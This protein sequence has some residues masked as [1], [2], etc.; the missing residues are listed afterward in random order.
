MNTLPIT[1]ATFLAAFSCSGANQT[2]APTSKSAEPTNGPSESTESLPL[3]CGDAAGCL[4][5]AAELDASDPELATHA[6][7][8]ACSAGAVEGCEQAGLRWAKAV[9]TTPSED[10]DQKVLDSWL[11]SCKLGGFH[12]CGNAGSAHFFGLWGAPVDVDSAV[13]YW[14]QSCTE[15]NNKF[16]CRKLD[17][18]N[19]G[20]LTPGLIP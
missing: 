1:I 17:Q 8:A 12:G 2:V 3:D 7:Y 4:A 6:Y 18:Y 14:T 20:D 13:K 5:H 19:K 11:R 10:L 16:I 9:K 15:Q